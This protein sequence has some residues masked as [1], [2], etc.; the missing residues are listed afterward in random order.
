MKRTIYAV[1]GLLLSVVLI[2]P[3]SVFA[4][5]KGASKDTAKTKPP[6]KAYSKVITSEAESD[7]G[8]F[9][10]HQIDSK[11]Y[12]EVP[13]SLL[14][15]DM[16]L[17]SRIAQTPTNY[18]GFLSG[19]AKVHE[20]VVRWEKK[21]KQLLLRIVSFN[22]VAA[23]SL[24]IYKAVQ[25][26]NYHP[27]IAAFKIE[28]VSPDSNAWVIEVSK[29]FTSDVR[30]I[31]PVPD[32]LRKAYQ[33]KNLDSKRSFVEKV[34]SYPI[35]VEVKHSLTYNAGKAPAQSSTGTMSFLMNQS[36]VLLPKE[37]MT[38][39]IYDPRVGWFTTSQIDF[40]S[41]ALK[42]DR[43]TY[44]RRWRLEPKDPEAY[45][46]GELVEPKKPIV[47]YL[48][49]ATPEKWR[50]WFKKGV[51]DWQ[52]CFEAAGFK[53]AIICKYP[54]TPE[55]DPEFSPEDARYSVIRYVANLTRNAMGPS[56]SD[57]R[58]GEI[59]ESDI[60]WF[61]NHIR[62]YRNRYLIETAAANPRARTLKLP[63]EDIGEMIRAV[64]AHEVGHTLG[65]PH[66]FK[67][68]AAYPI[69]SLRNGPFT[70]KNGISPSI[71]DYARVN[72]VAQPGDEGIRFIRKVGPYDAYA[73]NWGYRWYPDVENPEQEIETL[74]KVIME[75][76][77]DP[78]YE[79]GGF[80]FSDPRYNRES[81]GDN[82]VEASRLGLANLKKVAPN[83]KKWTTGEN[84]SYEDLAEVYREFAG[85]WNR[86]ISHVV[87]VIGGVKQDFKYSNQEGPIFTPVDPDWQRDAMKFI[88]KDVFITPE[89]LVNPEITSYIRGEGSV[90]MV[91]SM[92]GRALRSLLADSR[93]NRM[94]ETTAQLS[95][96]DSY[97]IQEMMRD[98]RLGIFAEVYPQGQRGYMTFPLSFPDIN[99][100][101]LQFE[102]INGL[103]T[104]VKAGYK[105]PSDIS[106]AALGELETLE[107]DLKKKVKQTKDVDQ[108][109]HWKM[110]LEL[111]SREID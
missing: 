105:K 77:G 94:M 5:D 15:R 98:L 26:S 50:P 34:S 32:R 58:S 60:M 17:V 41:E 111:V 63:E 74:Q 11:L 27:I 64:I 73:V 37:T 71:M 101:N 48:D 33:V 70:H 96:E 14:G 4:Q 10:V 43:K 7:E 55:E 79:F 87:A 92:Q 81:L 76:A 40:G 83:L 38:P 86:Y 93:L 24:P 22:S 69:D 106:S 12:F 91:R 2:I 18:S 102:L 95:G 88:I 13:D 42:A 46:R 62:S 51:E 89:W 53:N 66:N 104:K 35:N 97:T 29:M 6:F 23:D 16:L 49:P 61:H 65:F 54:P 39:R 30:A 100:R 36:M 107:K 75:K 44:I 47:Y 85:Q 103:R 20:Q 3:Q 67:S 8:L 78:V 99:R 68:S 110:C 59:L 45:M 1:C 108:G 82:M 25:N 52:P 21:H 84:Q 19:G 109:K 9:K 80:S 57:P 31:G 90:E 28:T 56:V 72:Y